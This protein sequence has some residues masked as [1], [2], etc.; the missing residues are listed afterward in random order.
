M[1]SP[2]C[3]PPGYY[4]TTEGATAGTT[5]KPCKQA[6]VLTFNPN[7]GSDTCYPVPEDGFCSATTPVST[8]GCGVVG[9]YTGGQVWACIDFQCTDG[10]YKKNLQCVPW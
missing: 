2:S 6:P 7:E 1:V 3:S 9:C 5:C 4:S 8:N 10:F